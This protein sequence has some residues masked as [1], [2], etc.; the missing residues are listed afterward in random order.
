MED[1][2]LIRVNKKEVNFILEW[3]TYMYDS[4]FAL[5]EETKLFEKIKKEATKFK[6][7]KEV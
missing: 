3:Y 7:C 5:A 6:A 2:I 4:S 1:L